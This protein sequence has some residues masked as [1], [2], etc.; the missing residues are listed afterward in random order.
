MYEKKILIALKWKCN[1][2]K[3]CAYGVF[4]DWLSFFDFIA[5][6]TKSGRAS[7]FVSYMRESFKRMKLPKYCLPKVGSK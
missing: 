3:I 5:K 6:V 4:K 7:Y 2:T 1:D